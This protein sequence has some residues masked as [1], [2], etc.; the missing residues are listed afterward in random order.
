MM[1]KIQNK[2]IGDGHPVFFIAEAGVNHNG[3]IE[4]GKK[5]IDCAKTACADAV[6]F[7]TFKTEN[8]ITKTAP[9]STYHIETT[10]DDKD[11]SWFELLKTQEMSRAM[12]IELI[13]HCKKVGIIFLSTPYDE[14]SA[15]LLE[16]LSVPAFKIASTDTGNI[17]LL[18]YIAKKGRPMILSSAMATMTEVE[19]AVSAVRGEG[20]Q[21]VA[22]LQCTG[23]Y[24]AKLADTNLRVM[25]TYRK[26]LKCIVGYS[27][28]TPDLINPIAATAMGACI[29]E[30]HFTVDR[31]LPGPDHRMSLNPK[32]LKE[33]IQAIRNTE[34]ALGS[35][36]KQVLDGEKEN[37][38]KLRKS[39]VANVDINKGNMIQKEMLAL[40]RPGHGI[41]PTDFNKVIG[42]TA[43]SDIS[44]GSVL[45]YEMLNDR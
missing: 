36:V 16:S 32:E 26:Q 25:E 41:Q 7:Q 15:D 12:H 13:E 5:L 11:Q 43:R 17:P 22:M 20:L 3:S 35:H 21:E 23:N 24:P 45:L 10:G 42:K 39:V 33:T 31:S 37:R 18:K 44:E 1:F 40:K 27:D 9:K 14:D 29:Y 19:D 28:H 8:I 34:T 30:K 6:K 2:S 4:L 38:V